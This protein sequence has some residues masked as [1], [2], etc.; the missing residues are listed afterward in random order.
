MKM[1]EAPAMRVLL[2]TFADPDIK[3]YQFLYVFW[4]VDLHFGI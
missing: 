1:K 2:F 4:A 3:N